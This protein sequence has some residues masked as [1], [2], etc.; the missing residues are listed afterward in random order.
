[1]RAR[2]SRAFASVCACVVRV[3][4]REREREDKSTGLRD[5]RAQSKGL[6]GPVRIV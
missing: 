2:A 4:E 1:M 3:R 6:Q 5:L